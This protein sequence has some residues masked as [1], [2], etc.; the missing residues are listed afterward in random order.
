MV[1]LVVA[2]YCCRALYCQYLVQPHSLVVG[3]AAFAC[4]ITLSM[5]LPHKP[6]GKRDKVIVLV[7]V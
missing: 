5:F 7:A 3:E 1:P 2:V 4:Y 6:N